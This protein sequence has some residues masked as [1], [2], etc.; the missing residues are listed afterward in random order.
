MHVAWRETYVAFWIDVH[1][2]PGVVEL[3][4]FFAYV[5]AVLDWFDSFLDV[6]SI[7]HAVINRRLRNEDNGCIW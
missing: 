6:V 5:S 1:F 3:H 4:V 2:R 7:D